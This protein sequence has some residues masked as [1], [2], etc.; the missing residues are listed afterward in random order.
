MPSP[1]SSRTPPRPGLKSNRQP[2][3]VAAAPPPFFARSLPAKTAVSRRQLADCRSATCHLPRLERRDGDLRSRSVWG[4]QEENASKGFEPTG[5]GGQWPVA[6]L[7]VPCY[8]S[9]AAA[10]GSLTGRLQLI[11]CWATRPRRSPTPFPFAV[12]AQGFRVGRAGTPPAPP[13]LAE[14]G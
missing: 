10:A 6:S 7:R 5:R 14:G 12:S 1:L 11:Y 2:V 3:P 9:R 13:R 4:A 8:R